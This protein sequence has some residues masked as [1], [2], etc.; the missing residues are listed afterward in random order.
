M[1]AI[2]LAAK[3]VREAR[4][5]AGLSQRDLALRARTAQSVV[6]RIEGGQ[7]SPSV[8]TLSRLLDAA[9]FTFQADISPRPAD[10]P[11]TEAYKRDI[12]RSLLLENLNRSPDDRIRA[13]AAL[14]A[15]ASEARRAGRAAAP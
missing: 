10:D 9:G 12:D 11:V 2:T 14:S 15:F 5:A 3:L 7:V 6:A 4:N 13:L 1:K 8:E